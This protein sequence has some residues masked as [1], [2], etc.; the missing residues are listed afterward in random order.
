[1]TTFNISLNPELAEIVEIAIKKWK[2]AN[3]SEFFRDLVRKYYMLDWA[4][5]EEISEWDPDTNLIKKREKD[6]EY[7]PFEEVIKNV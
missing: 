2:Y 5:I 3:R 4:Y 6:A 7:I 1:M